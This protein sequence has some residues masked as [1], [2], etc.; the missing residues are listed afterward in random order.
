MSMK[1]LLKFNFLIFLI[2]LLILFNVQLNLIANESSAKTLLI[3][4]LSTGETL[5]EKNPNE[6]IQPSSM[7]KILTTL[8][9]FEKIKNGLIS[10]DQ[11]FLVSEKAWKMGGSKMF[12]EVDAKVKVAG[13]HA[14]F[15]GFSADLQR[16]LP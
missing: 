15:D 9:A 8:V 1:K 7:T 13:V 2:S 6:K 11:E 3:I 16:I 12:I 14:A 10:M 5:F 4:D